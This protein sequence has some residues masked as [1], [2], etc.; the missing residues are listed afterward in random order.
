MK[1]SVFL[2]C[3]A[4]LDPVWLWPREE[5]VAEALATF[6]TAAR[7]C[8][9]YDGFVFNH[10]EAMLYQWIEQYDPDLF[11]EIQRLVQQGR[12]HI[13]G[14]WYLQPDCNM[15]SGESFVRQ[16]LEGRRY[17]WEKFGVSPSTAINFDSFGHS[18]GLVQILKKAGYDSYVVCRPGEQDFQTPTNDF[19]WE[20]YDGSRVLVHRTFDGYQSG[21][22]RAG[23]KAD[24]YLELPEQDGPYLC[25]WG[26]GNHGGGPSKADLEELNQRIRENPRMAHAMP[27]DFFRALQEIGKELPVVAK[28]MN[29]WGIGCY[30]SEIRVKQRH[31]ELEGAYYFLEKMGVHASLLGTAPYPKEELQQI[32][33]DLLF[34]EF[35]D[36]LPGTSAEKSEQQSLRTAAHGLEIAARKQLDL[37]LSMTWGRI[38]P[39][40]AVTPLYLYNPHPVPVEGIFEYEL[41]LAKSVKEGFAQPVLTWNGQPVPVQREKEDNMVPIQWRRKIAFYAKLPPSSMSRMEFDIQV[42]PE[43]PVADSVTE[44]EKELLFFNDR[45]E[46]RIDRQ[47]GFVN[48]YRVDGLDYLKPG[49]FSPVVYENIHDSWGMTLQKYDTPLTPFRLRTMENGQPEL[50]VIE[51]GPVRTMIEGVYEYG[52]SLL[53]MHYCLPKHGTEMEVRLN[54]QFAEDTKLIK[55]ALYPAMDS[56]EFFGETAYGVQVLEQNRQEEVAQKWLAAADDRHCLTLINDGVYGSSCDGDG[57]YQTLIQSCGYSAHP[58]EGRQHIPTDRYI[59][60]SDHIRTEYR[61]WIKGGPRDNRLQEVSNEALIHQQPPMILA[62]FSGKCTN[63]R[64]SVWDLDNPAILVPAIKRAE[65]GNGIVYRFFNS[66]DCTQEA[67]FTVQGTKSTLHFN[68]FEIKTLLWDGSSFRETDLLEGLYQKEETD[69]E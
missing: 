23:L 33:K 32:R 39:E 64:Q 53:I 51:D 34:L 25:L 10:N 14:G 61:F 22:G 13:M 56:Y 28:P 47:T 27:E 40:S 30:T 2:L 11:A 16:I 48:T 21:Y 12:W 29:H 36:I 63:S 1:T 38:A 31:R 45:M 4:H 15:P 58:M 9:E 66:T 20:G 26:V 49:S 18:R 67:H 19:W 3:N 54:L 41:Q 24:K 46:V 68:P 6:E 42:L 69:H 52:H 35:H 59:Q 17:F 62:A 7:F 57:I 43:P 55:L 50:R 8:R 44:T 37:F 65:T 5:G 60:N